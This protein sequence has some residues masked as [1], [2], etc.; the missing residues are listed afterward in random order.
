MGMNSAPEL[1]DSHVLESP[2]RR[3]QNSLRA[4]VLADRSGESLSPLD[5]RG[6]V[7]LLPIASRPMIHYVLEDLARSGVS[8][9][10]VAASRGSDQI[11]DSLG[12]GSRWGIA[13]EHVLTRGEASLDRVLAKLPGRHEPWLAIRGDLFL[14]PCAS[15]FLDVVAHHPTECAAAV[16]SDGRTLPIAWVR[17]DQHCGDVLASPDGRRSQEL[18]PGF[19]PIPLHDVRMDPLSSHATYHRANVDVAHGKVNGLAPPGTSVAIGLVAGRRSRFSLRTIRGGASLIGSHVTVQPS[20]EI[21]GNVVLSDDTYVDHRVTLENS[22]VLPHTYVGELL[23]VRNAIVAGDLL[24]RVDTGAM[25]RITDDLLLSDLGRNPITAHLSEYAQRILGV[26]VLLL[27]LPL[28]PLALLLALWNSGTSLLERTEYLGNTFR[29]R[30]SRHRD[31]L[32]LSG[33]HFRCKPPVLRNLPLLIAVVRGHLRMVGVTPM[34]PDE[35]HQVDDWQ[36]LR[37][38]APAGLLGLAQL[39]AHAKTATIERHMMD[40]VLSRTLTRGSQLTWLWRGVLALFSK[41]AWGD[42]PKSWT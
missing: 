35:P 18:P 32:R 7:C 36:K 8:R 19:L 24:I 40:V 4:I 27:S 20:A 22:V 42:R 10:V 30:G 37:Q 29:V 16:D 39:T 6:P 11:R 5:E 38:E 25:M 15:A 34:T 2:P 31:R 14:A 12:D 9:V 13:I 26:L 17:S 21:L 3:L 1:L 41:R 23:E 33:W 28:W